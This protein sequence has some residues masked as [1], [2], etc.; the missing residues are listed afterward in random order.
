[1]TEFQP[2]QAPES[3]DTVDKVAKANT[4]PYILTPAEQDAAIEEREK[5]R[6]ER[7]EPITLNPDDLSPQAKVEAMKRAHMTQAEID[8]YFAEHHGEET[9]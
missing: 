2:G 9:P 5:A 7:R 6:G 1:M 4:N 8:A 3:D